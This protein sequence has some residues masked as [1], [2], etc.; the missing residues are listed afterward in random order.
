MVSLMDSNLD[1][2]MKGLRDLLEEHNAIM[3]VDKEWT[4]NIG[5]TLGG[6]ATILPGTT[7]EI[8][9]DTLD[10]SYIT[11]YLSEKG[12]ADFKPVVGDTGMDTTMEC[13]QCGYK[14]VENFDSLESENEV[15]RKH[16][17]ER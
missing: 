1:K 11:W 13:I 7:Y 2:F 8:T 12:I 14:Y 10:P 4:H 15:K 6:E 3:W 9:G 5:F 16:K 17:C